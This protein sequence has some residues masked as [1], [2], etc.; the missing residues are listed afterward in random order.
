MLENL[1]ARWGRAS[2]T[3][4]APYEQLVAPVAPRDRREQFLSLFDPSGHGLEIGASFNP[5]L[6]KA[7]GYD[8]KVLDH[9]TAEELVRKYKNAGVDVRK[10]ETVDYVTDGGSLLNAVGQEGCF[11]FI[12]ASHVVE[13][14]VS[15]LG[16]LQDCERL[17]TPKGVLVLA[18]PDKRFSFDALRPTS[19]TGDVLQA[20][21]EQRKLHSPG[22]LFDEVA[23]NCLRTGALSWGRGDEGPLAFAAPLQAAKD[24]FEATS[25]D[26]AFHDIHAWQFTPSS[27]RLIV[28]DL[29]EIGYLGLREDRAVEGNGEFF[30]TL[31]RGATGSGLSRLQ[32]AQG[33]IAESREIK[34]PASDH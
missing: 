27:F 34:V 17:L 13:H 8:V 18:V 31:A 33:V 5:L 24:I 11:D 22:A 19:S 30:I 12:V 20:H 3:L 29:H 32:L 2:T 4:N 21:L 16:F 1:L 7:D 15:F 25:R 26:P 9:A 14:T 10:I 28:N 23:Y 6:P